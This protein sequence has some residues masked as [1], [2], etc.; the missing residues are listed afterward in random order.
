M[1]VLVLGNYFNMSS[2]NLRLVSGA[3]VDKE[4]FVSIAE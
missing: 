3:L 4:Y 2:I 1:D